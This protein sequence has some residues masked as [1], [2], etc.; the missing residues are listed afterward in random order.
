MGAQ[1]QRK[2]RVAELEAENEQL[3]ARV[4]ELE[5]ARPVKAAK[6]VPAPPK[7]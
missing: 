7:S 5:A 4:A 6:A 3:R 1:A 2:A